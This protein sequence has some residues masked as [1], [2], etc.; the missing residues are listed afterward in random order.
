MK[1]NEINLAMI[2]HI[3]KI[4]FE[5]DVIYGVLLDD[6]TEEYHRLIDWL[7]SYMC[8]TE[9]MTSKRKK[10]EILDGDG[11]SWLGASEWELS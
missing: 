11:L 8:L 6:L 10:K 1:Q 5:Y 9:R 2:V 4:R 3:K 7:S